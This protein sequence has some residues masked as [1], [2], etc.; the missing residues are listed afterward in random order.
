MIVTIG[1][2]VQ[3]APTQWWRS[4]LLYVFGSAIG[5]MTVFVGIAYVGH[6]TLE[7][8]PLLVRW[9]LMGVSAG[10]L[11]LREFGMF[12]WR[13][14]MIYR[15]IPRRWWGRL[16]PDRG[17]L[18]WGLLLGAGVTTIIPFTTFYI[19]GIWAA[20]IGEP[21][22]GAALGLSYGVARALPV[23]LASGALARSHPNSPRVAVSRIAEALA[24]RE[25]MLYMINGT[26]LAVVAGA[27]FSTILLTVLS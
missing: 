6:Y 2:L 13:L 26:A 10:A 22:Y 3:E 7:Q 27:T 16:G 12:T 23:I 14:P 9:G 4:S 11:S 25:G 18:L 19:V 8:I 5:G 1:P 20:L 24:S 17:A 15:T 21:S